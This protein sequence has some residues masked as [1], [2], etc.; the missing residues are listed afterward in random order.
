MKVLRILLGMLILTMGGVGMILGAMMLSVSMEGFLYMA[1]GIALWYIYYL[2]FT[3]RG[4]AKRASAQ[5]KA[6]TKR[7]KKS[8][9]L[10]I[11]DGEHPG[12][13]TF[14]EKPNED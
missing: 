3:N 8:N 2:L 10:V 6:A 14:T 13:G 9:H 4:K 11:E 5:A 1:C 12:T 7:N